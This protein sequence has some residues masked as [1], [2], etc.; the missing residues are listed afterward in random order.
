MS[1]CSKKFIRWPWMM[2]FNS[3]KVCSCLSPKKRCSVK[4]WCHKISNVFQDFGS[5]LVWLGLRPCRIEFVHPV[6]RDF[7]AWCCR[8]DTCALVLDAWCVLC[9]ENWRELVLIQSCY[10]SNDFLIFLLYKTSLFQKN[11]VYRFQKYEQKMF[12]FILI[13]IV[14]VKNN[15]TSFWHCWMWY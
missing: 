13:H 6:F 1:C 15:K 8:G 7:D 5:D 12:C 9:G 10:F 3:L 2:C 11:F 14:L 4:C